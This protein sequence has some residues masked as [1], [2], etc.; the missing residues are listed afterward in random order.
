MNFPGHAAAILAALIAIGIPLTGPF[1]RAM[2]RSDPKNPRKF[3]AYGAN[4]ILLW[5]LLAAAIGIDGL[6]PLLDSPAQGS[7]WLW[8]PGIF[9]PVLYLLVT[10][11]MVAGLLPLFQ[12]LRGDRW[13]QAYAAATRRNFKDIPQLMP[14]T[15][16]ERAAWVLLSFSAGICE[17][18]ACRSF[19]IRFLHETITG[20]PLVGALAASSVIFGLAHLYQGV[21]GVLGTAIGGFALGLLFLLS[22]SLIP[23][24]VLHVLL[25]LQVAYILR[26]VQTPLLNK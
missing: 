17:E 15:A 7:D 14:D 25:D 16:A 9:R 2:Y 4:I 11:Y 23:S 13:R 20:M 1:E 19:M 24:I 5:G 3:I 6:A 8:A 18:I 12:S 22:E 21:K 10:A 26:P